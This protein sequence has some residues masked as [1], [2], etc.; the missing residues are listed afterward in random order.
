MRTMIKPT[1]EQEEWLRE[2]YRMYS[3][4][5]LLVKLRIANELLSKW[6]KDMGLKKKKD[7]KKSTLTDEDKEY[8]KDNFHSMTHEGIA[9]KLG[10]TSSA[11]RMYCFRNNLKKK[12]SE[13]FIPPPKK[14]I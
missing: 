8:I 4:Y 1:H 12:G 11:V 13:K 7:A 14:I 9:V 3:N 10:V 2:F 5:H 6:L